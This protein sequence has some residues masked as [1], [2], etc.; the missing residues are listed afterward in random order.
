MSQYEEKNLSR[1]Y[2]AIDNKGKFVSL[3][4][5]AASLLKV[6]DLIQPGE[7]YPKNIDL[8]TIK[9]GRLV[10]D[11]QY[12]KKK[13][14]EKT[15]LKAISIFVEISK[16]IGVIGLTV[17]AKKESAG[18]YQKYGFKDLNSKKD[19]DFVPMILYTHIL[20]TRRPS[21]FEEPV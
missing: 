18:F 12:L 11:K 20:R 6:D 17:D 5:L 16:R 14:G 4:C 15:L 2:V 3:M 8:P 13:I 1:N 19:K 7:S 21:L 9:I 10:V